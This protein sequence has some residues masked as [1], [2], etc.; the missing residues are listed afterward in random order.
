MAEV[1]LFDFHTHTFPT[2]ERGTGW[3]RSIGHKNPERTG[4]IDELRGMMRSANISR[5]VML[6]YTPT[7]YMYEARLR[8]QPLPVDP[9]ERERVSREIKSTM[10]ERAIVNNE[11]QTQQAREHPELISFCGID[12]VYMD[13]NTMIV[14]I[15]D[16][17]EKGAMGV[18]IVPIALEIY[19][20]DPRLW[21]V[22][23]HISRL[24]IPMLSQAGGRRSP[25]GKDAWGSPKYFAEALEAFSNL[26]LIVAHMANGCEDQVIDLCRRFPNFYADLSMRLHNLNQPGEMT[27]DEMVQ[28]IR[29]CGAEHIIHGSNFPICDPR[30]FADAV[31]S[32]GL[33]P[34][35]FE[36]IASGN[37]KRVLN[38]S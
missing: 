28:L 29:E 2:P 31:R 36:L 35:E 3:L 12:P 1:E 5:A 24:G 33:K 4:T 27:T 32:L 23:E 16:K 38:L 10:V 17:L 18:K 26:T 34:E 19:G 25:E 9:E 30:Q 11:W 22:Y 14:E 6:C 21:P 15:D 20:N 7:R 8:Q 37:A 13:A